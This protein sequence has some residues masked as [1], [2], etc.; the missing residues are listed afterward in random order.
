MRW[1]ASPAADD[2]LLA[3]LAHEAGHVAHRHGVQ[4]IIQDSL[5]AFAIS[6]VTGDASGTSQLFLGLPVM[7]TELAYSRDFERE[8]DRYA[9]DTLRSPGHHRRGISPT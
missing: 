2:E 7:L 5:L 4:R 9:L 8:A 6:A 3:V 1:S